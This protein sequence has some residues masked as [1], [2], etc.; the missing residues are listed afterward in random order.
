MT[1]GADQPQDP[2]KIVAAIHHWRTHFSAFPCLYVWRACRL[3]KL[4][5]RHAIR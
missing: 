3:R 2:W 5:I 1:H 4:G